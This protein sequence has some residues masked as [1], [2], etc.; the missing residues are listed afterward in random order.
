MRTLAVVAVTGFVAVV[1]AGQDVGHARRFTVPR[2]WDEAALSSLELPLADPRMNPQHVPAD[3]YY[4]IPIRHLY[5]S[6]PVYHPA[7]EPKPDGMDYQAWL[8]QQRPQE[9]LRDFSALTTEADWLANGPTLGRDVFEGAIGDELDPALGIIQL[10]DVHNPDWYKATGVQHTDKGIVPYVRYVVTDQGLH[11]GQFACAMCHTRVMK[12]G[13][14]TL[15]IQGAQGDFPLDRVIAYSTESK[16]AA[17]SQSEALAEERGVMRFLFA[18]PWLSPGPLQHLSES[19]FAETMATYKAIPPGVNARHGTSPLSPVQ[20]PDLIGVKERR[21][22]DRT[23]LVRH[24][25]AGDVM[26]YAALNQ[27]ADFLNRF[28][29]FTPLTDGPADLPGPD[30]VGARYSDEQLYAL[31][32]FVYSLRPPPNPN[33]PKNAQEK[34]LVAQ[35]EDMFQREG[36]ASCHR[37]PAY[38]SN[39]L[40]AAPGYKVPANHPERTRVLVRRVGTDSFLT[41]QTRRGTGLY[42]IP[43]LKGVWYR[44]PFE[45]NGSIAALEDWFDARR[46]EDDYVPTGWKGP[47]GTTVRAV[48]GHEFGLDLSEEEKRALIA[49]LK[50]L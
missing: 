22:F 4:K 3:Y 49:F 5:K 29:T 7:F 38:T 46:L 13:D 43:S 6:Y 23:G 44:G 45:H 16:A 20:V 47:P 17:R 12:R 15:V 34:A 11:L 30:Q 35:G 28:G 19:S 9:I 10:S 37:P 41:L 39:K 27:G 33:T 24:R 36:C 25:D 32:L 1:A 31:A 42:K 18:A 40:V 48:K 8:R 21:Y 26:R 2:A 14:I 50:T